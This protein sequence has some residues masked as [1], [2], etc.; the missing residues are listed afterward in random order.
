VSA[1]EG[2]E[3]RALALELAYARLEVEV[4]ALM[5]C[6]RE[7][8]EG[9]R[10]HVFSARCAYCGDGHRAEVARAVRTLDEVREVRARERGK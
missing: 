4:R 9:E 1:R 3:A 8:D 2:W 7:M 5:K 10:A 6:A